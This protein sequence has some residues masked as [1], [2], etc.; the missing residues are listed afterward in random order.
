VYGE[1]GIGGDQSQ[2]P[3][4]VILT[5]FTAKLVHDE[6][7]LL[8]WQTAQEI[9]ADRFIIQ[10]STDQL[11]WIDRGSVNAK[12]FS[13]STNNYSFFDDLD[14]NFGTV[15]Y[16]LLQ[17]DL[18]GKKHFSPITS[19]TQNKTAEFA[20]FPNPTADRVYL[21]GVVTNVRIY[22]ITGLQIMQ[23]EKDGWLDI[24]QLNAGIY[25]VKQERK[26]IKLIK[27]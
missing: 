5:A 2:N 14:K 20:V 12:G 1:Y 21:Q 13:A 19:L 9:N 25:F 6:K 11:N 24:T 7:A 15:Y 26:V 17:L 10:R 8:Q 23:V 18:N 27:Q 4:P 22:D 3:L 16:R